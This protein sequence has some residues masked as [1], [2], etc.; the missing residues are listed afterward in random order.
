M[1][2][3]A[4]G[5]TDHPEH[6]QDQAGQQDDN[7]DRPEDDDLRDEPDDKKDD[8]EDDQLW[9][10]AV[11]GRKPCCSQGLEQHPQG[12]VE[13]P[14]RYRTSLTEVGRAHSE[15]AGHVEARAPDPVHAEA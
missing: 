8:A 14:A 12:T 3:A 13:K 6:G 2:A 4:D 5:V 1:S 11:Q 9:L 10:P 15:W 7:A